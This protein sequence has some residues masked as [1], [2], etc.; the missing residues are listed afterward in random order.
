MRPLWALVPVRSFKSGKSRL[1]GVGPATREHLARALCD[2]VL[3]TLAASS[4]VAGIAVATDGD[5]VAEAALRH[6]A[7]VIFDPPKHGGPSFAALLDRGLDLLCTRGATAA[8]VVMADLPRLTVDDVAA[9]IR[10]LDGADV[11]LAPDRYQLGTNALALALPAA[12]AT[13]FGH[14]DSYPRHLAAA[15]ER[16]LTT[17]SCVRGGLSFDLDWPDDL[18][19]LVAHTL[20]ASEPETRVLG[21]RVVGPEDGGSIGDAIERFELMSRAVVTVQNVGPVEGPQHAVQGRALGGD[22]T[23]A[24]RRPS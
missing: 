12:L 8:A 1:A 3:G 19:A 14:G 16:G 5:D 20:A 10:G 17:A 7:S 6:G 18:A 9:L 22:P 24:T 11:V 23:D 2:H 15:I 21:Q 13:C 4:E